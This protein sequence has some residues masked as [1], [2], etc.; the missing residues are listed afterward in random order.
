MANTRVSANSVVVNLNGTDANIPRSTISALGNITGGN[1]VT[2]GTL[3]ATGVLATTLTTTG[4]IAGGNLRTTGLISAAGT[5]TGGNLAVGSGFISGGNIISAGPVSAGLGMSAAGNVQGGNILTTGTVTA[6]GNI[7]GNFFIGNGSQLTGI[8]GTS[9]SANA[10]LLIGSTLSSNVIYSQLTSVG[11]LSLL[12]VAGNITGNYILG[13]GSQL[14]GI[15]TNYNNSN[16]TTLLSSFGSN[17]ISTTGNI[18]GGNLI[19]SG[20]IATLSAVKRVIIV[21]NTA[22]TGSDGAVGDIWYQTY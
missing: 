4:N 3:R 22:P 20:N 9:G 17:T 14:T 15:T 11:I 10:A 16:V 1:L 5:I 6:T 19:S 7:R 2:T 13:N 21:A 18:N 12:S 8:T